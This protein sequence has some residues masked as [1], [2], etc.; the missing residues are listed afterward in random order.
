MNTNREE[1]SIMRCAAED[2]RNFDCCSASIFSRT[3]ESA[4]IPQH[5]IENKFNVAIVCGRFQ[6]LLL[7][8]N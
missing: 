4:L 8:S 1:Y 3:S 6:L 2:K 7:E 5:L